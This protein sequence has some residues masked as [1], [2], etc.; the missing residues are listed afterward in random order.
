M[1]DTRLLPVTEVETEVVARAGGGRLV[2]RVTL[3]AGRGL[4]STVVPR[5]ETL[6]RRG[7][8]LI[9]AQLNIIAEGFY[10]TII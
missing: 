9:L 7:L 3:G 10:L 5:Y 1:R 4:L 6:A 2:Y 8:K